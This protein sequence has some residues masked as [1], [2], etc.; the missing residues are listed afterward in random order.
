MSTDHITF[1]LQATNDERAEIERTGAIGIGAY[2]ESASGREQRL[3]FFSR[4]AH[5]RKH[6]GVRVFKPQS[7]LPQGTL[8]MD[9][10]MYFET[11][12]EAIAFTNEIAPKFQVVG[13]AK[14]DPDATRVMV[15]DVT[16][17]E[18]E[19]YVRRNSSYDNFESYRVEAMA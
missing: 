13:V 1:L 4:E 18:A 3:P 2:T 5:D 16:D 12:E 10:E 14:D 7:Y 8:G 11:K 17:E 9:G 19:E 6:F 15:T